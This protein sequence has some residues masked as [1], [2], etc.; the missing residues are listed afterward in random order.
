MYADADV[1]M[2]EEGSARCGL[3]R[4]RV[5]GVKIVKFLQK[6]FM[7]SPKAKHI[8]LRAKH[9]AKYCTYIASPRPSKQKSRFKHNDRQT[10]A[11]HTCI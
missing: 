11:Y 4:T 7:D 1:R 10:D 2:G 6:S 3:K 5:R 9:K 8:T